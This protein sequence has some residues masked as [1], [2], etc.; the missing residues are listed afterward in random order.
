MDFVDVDWEYP[1]SVRQ[2]DLVDNKNDEGT[3]NAVP[4]DKEIIYYYYKIY[5]ML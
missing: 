5:V 4:Q 2:P 3:P 1:G